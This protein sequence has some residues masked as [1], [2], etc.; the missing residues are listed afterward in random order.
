MKKIWRGF[1]LIE[2]M[3]SIAILASISA[4]L[5]NIF[6][7]S[8]KTQDASYKILDSRRDARLIRSILSD[9]IKKTLFLKNWAEASL[10][11]KSG[12]LGVTLRDT[13]HEIDQIY[14]HARKKSSN[15]RLLK[16]YLDPLVHEVGYYVKRAEPLSPY[17]S[18]YRREYFYLRKGFFEVKNIFELSP[19]IDP[20]QVEILVT[21]RLTRF[22]ISYL[23]KAEGEITTWVWEDKWDSA[24]KPANEKLPLA[25]KVEFAFL[26][27]EDKVEE[28]SFQVNLKP[29]LPSGSSWGF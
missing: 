24:S 28:V 7:Q 5:L 21:D 1:S 22:K 6:Y 17:Y 4:L 20:R 11:N 19:N 18:L 8:K 13:T 2:L 3:V 10:E 16:E 15:Y 29:V 14:F 25:V 26:N 23:A 27:R 9:D 12:I